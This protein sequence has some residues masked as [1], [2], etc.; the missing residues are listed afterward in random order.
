[1]RQLL[2]ILTLVFFLGCHPEKNNTTETL[3][4]TELVDSTREMVNEKAID[5]IK[6][7]KS[8]PYTDTTMFVVNRYKSEK[9]F[10]LQREYKTSLSPYPSF[11]RLYDDSGMVWLMFPSAD[12]DIFQKV[13][14]LAKGPILKRRE[15]YVICPFDSSQT[16]YEGLFRKVHGTSYA[17]GEH[18]V[19]YESGELHWLIKYDSLTVKGAYQKKPEELVEYD[20]AGNIL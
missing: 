14:E 13:H 4:S 2:T 17:I 6:T 3:K 18:K 15:A 11:T 9:L 12:I 10:G 8:Y 5:S 7:V 19:Y 1:M 16:W 20:K